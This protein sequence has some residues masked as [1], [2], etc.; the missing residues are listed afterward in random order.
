MMTAAVSES[1]STV[2]L[3]SPLTVRVQ[4][5]N[6][7]KVVT[8]AATVEVDIMPHL[9]RVKEGGDFTGYYQTLQNLDAAFV[10][11][12]PWFAYP[13]V[14]VAELERP[15]CSTNRSTWNATLI[16]SVVADF[17]AAVCGPRAAAGDCDGGRSVVPQLSTMPAWLYEPDGVNR[18]FNVPADPWQWP[19][20]RFD[21]YLVKGKKLR[22]PTCRE[23][24]RYAARCQFARTGPTP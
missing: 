14:A 22:D 12:S 5:D 6:V 16:S 18:T 4:W 13:K 21:Y 2:S 7:T 23:M 15:D 1:L 17:M 20:G 19:P 8:T 24:A 3:P 11:F 10:R 9:A